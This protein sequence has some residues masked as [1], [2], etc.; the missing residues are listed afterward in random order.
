VLQI[1]HIEKLELVARHPAG[2]VCRGADGQKPCVVRPE[3]MDISGEAV[4]DEFSCNARVRGIA[5]V[6]REKR[7]RLAE[8]DHIT[9][10]PVKAH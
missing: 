5:E 1:T 9:P 6:E 10:V 4:D 7:V 2:G 8:I 3:E